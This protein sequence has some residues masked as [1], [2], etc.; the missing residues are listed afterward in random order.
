[1][2]EVKHQKIFLEDIIEKLSLKL[3]VETI[4]EMREIDD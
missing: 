3:D 1:M 2:G 4:K